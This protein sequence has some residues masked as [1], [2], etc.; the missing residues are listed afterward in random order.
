MKQVMYVFFIMAVAGVAALAGAIAGGAAVYRAV[1]DR[2][3]VPE[4]VQQI[5]P[6]NNTTPTQVL[7]L[8]STDV[9]TSITQSVREV[10]P[11]VVTVVGTIPGQLTIFGPTGD[12]TV[13]GTGFF[14]TN[15]GYIITNNHVVEGT[16]EVG[17]I[18][19]D[20]TQQTADF[21]GSDPYSDIAVLKADGNVP[22]V[23]A[24][25][26]SDALDPG[27]SVIAIGS[28]L[29]DFKNTVTV[30]VVSAT[31]RSIDTG[32]GYAIENLIQTD[33]AINQGNSGGP[34]VNLAGEVIGV[35][36]LVVRQSP[37]G[38]VAE[39]L[40]FAIPMNTAQAI[41]QQII[42][43][44]YFARPYMGVSFQ[45]I[46]PEIAARY[47]LPAEWGVFIT[48]VEPSSPASEAGIQE[49]DI[50]IQVGDI[51]LDE[52]HSYVNALFSYQPGDRIPLVVMRDGQQTELQITLGEA[53]V[54]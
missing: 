53:P 1:Q 51:A 43:Q 40:G 3:N 30:G 15:D 2:E 24:L 36:T 41:A 7:T 25:G 27:E 12:Q 16:Q 33:A 42:E 28:P 22:A 20:G 10:G 23:A 35:N 14:I 19:S 21:V 13:S 26:N 54:R 34:L 32:K 38:S 46:N 48:N 50:I 11:T 37:S 47:D 5:L 6:G 31:G 44:G 17:I 4:A 39:G 8:S 29:G 45:P 49:G 52:T 18:L 9:E